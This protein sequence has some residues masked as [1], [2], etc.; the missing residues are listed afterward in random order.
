MVKGH[1][2][3]GI[4]AS[5]NALVS[6]LSN[7]FQSAGSH[8][9]QEDGKAKTSMPNLPFSTATDAIGASRSCL[10]VK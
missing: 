6:V 8:G 7:A 1:Q 5:I 3:D 2:L 9:V 10:I 4:S